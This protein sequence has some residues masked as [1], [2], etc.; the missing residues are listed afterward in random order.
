MS[1]AD[2]GAFVDTESGTAHVSRHNT[3]A[4]AALSCHS[5]DT[6]PSYAIAGTLWRDTNTPSATLQAV[7]MY[8]G[9]DWIP[10]G[11]LDITNNRWAFAAGSVSLPGIAFQGDADSGLYWIGA[12][13]Y[14]LAAAGAKVMEISAAGE[15]TQPLQPMFQARNTSTDANQTGDGTEATIDVDTE[16]FDQGGDFASDTFTAPVDGKYLLGGI[17]QLTGLGAGHTSLYAQIVTSNRRYTVASC[18]PIVNAASGTLVLPLATVLADMDAADT[19]YVVCAVS[20]STKTVGFSGNATTGET[21][22]FGKLV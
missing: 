13:N 6:A 3:V 2:P 21:I 17:I 18:N 1:Q 15:I 10:V 19:A 7:S 20:G 11:Y 4:A 8:D 14:A 16:T 22:F 9:T 12:N 5:G